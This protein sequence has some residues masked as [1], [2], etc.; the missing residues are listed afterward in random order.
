MTVR[1]LIVDDQD[2]FRAV[3]PRREATTEVVM[4]AD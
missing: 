2:P 4:V 1:V 3:A